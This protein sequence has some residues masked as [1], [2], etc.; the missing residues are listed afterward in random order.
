MPPRPAT[1]SM[2]YPANSEPGFR[3][4]MPTV[5]SA[6]ADVRQSGQLLERILIRNA[7]VAAQVDEQRGRGRH[8]GAHAGAEVALDALGDGVGAT[9]GLEPVEVEPE[10]PRPFP[11]VRLVEV[12]LVGEQRIVHR[13]ERPLQASGLDGLSQDP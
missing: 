3:S 13:P 5:I 11:Q 6:T 2:T 7:G 1:S 10:P 12:A 8:A 4:G 9:V